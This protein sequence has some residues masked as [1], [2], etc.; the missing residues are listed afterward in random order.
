MASVF[1][2]GR[3]R[4]NGMKN[5]TKSFGESLLS[6]VL[7]DCSSKIACEGAGVGRVIRFF[8]QNRS[9]SRR[10][11]L[12]CTIY[13]ILPRRATEAACPQSW[14]EDTWCACSGNLEDI[15]I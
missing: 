15:R 4:R 2:G 13:R 1:D 8:I 3:T 5:R 7:Y 10:H 11:R 12:F 6:V 14:R 9:G